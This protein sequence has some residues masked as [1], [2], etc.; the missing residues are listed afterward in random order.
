[1][2]NIN[3]IFKEI[4]GVPDYLGHKID[5]VHYKNGRGDTPLHIV[6]CWGNTEAMRILVAA[7][8]DINAKGESGF[9]PLHCAAEQNCPDAIKFLISLGAVQIRNDNGELPLE[10]AVTLNNSEAINAFK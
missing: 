4:E 7:G 1:M 6:S 3:E 5:S 10:L 8:A 9:T 2:N